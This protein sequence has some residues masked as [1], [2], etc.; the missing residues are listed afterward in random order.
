MRRSSLWIL[1]TVVSLVL[2]ACGGGSEPSTT[3][4]AAPTSTQE[5]AGPSESTTTTTDPTEAVAEFY[6]GKTVRFISGGGAG[7]GAG[8]YADL[9]GAH[10]GKYIPGNPT[11]VVEYRPGAGTMLSANALFNTDP[12]DGTVIGNF[13][14][15]MMVADASGVEEVQFK[16][17]EFGIIGS[18][19]AAFLACGAHARSGIT[20]INQI[21][22]GGQ[23]LIVG[24]SG[25]GAG[26]HDTPAA[27]NAAIGSNFEIISGYEA[28][29]GPI[30]LAIERNEI[31]GGCGVFSTFEVAFRELMESGDMKILVTIGNRP[32]DHPWLQGVPRAEDLAV[33]ADASALLELVGAPSA[34]NWPTATP[35]GV[36]QERLD[37]LRK[38]FLDVF[39]DP[40]L[41]AAA[42]T[43][44]LGINV[45]DY[46]AVLAV[47]EGVNAT[48]PSVFERFQEISG[49]GN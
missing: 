2:A 3:T 1:V 31:D 11:V 10:L 41:R 29:G 34:V 16:F 46:E 4:S 45:Q 26:N 33:D 25:P 22:S 39:S 13:H 7:A 19:D 21:I 40:E 9:I 38:A 15:N 18:P 6:S 27:L 12:R 17:D 23:K 30:R 20:D 36:P 35:P 14:A 43:A 28:G 44:N 37:A 8:T 49:G 48:P 5:S 47:W 24:A 42:E 32:D